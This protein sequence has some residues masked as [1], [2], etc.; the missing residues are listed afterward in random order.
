MTI[1]PA[2]QFD[3]IVAHHRVMDEEAQPVDGKPTDLWWYGGWSPRDLK[4]PQIEVEWNSAHAARLDCRREVPYPND[5]RKRCDL[6]TDGGW[7]EVKGLWPVYWESLGKRTIYEAYLFDPLKPYPSLGKDHTVARD[8]TKLHK[9]P[10]GTAIGLVL[11]GFDSVTV[12]CDRDITAFAS[13]AKL[14]DWWYGHEQWPNMQRP[15]EMVQVWSWLKEIH[16]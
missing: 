12:P 7:I 15:G 9:L 5:P 14:T 16:D 4:Q 1:A 8:I 10:D 13:L 3:R 6:V 11:I 2:N